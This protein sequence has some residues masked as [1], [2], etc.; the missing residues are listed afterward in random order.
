MRSEGSRRGVATVAIQDDART[1]RI[2]VLRESGILRCGRG[3]GSGRRSRARVGGSGW[4][5][6]GGT[7]YQAACVSVAAW[8]VRRV[9]SLPPVFMLPGAGLPARRRSVAG[10]RPSSAGPG[11]SGGPAAPA[12]RRRCPHAPAPGHGPVQAAGQR[13]IDRSDL[14]GRRCWRWSGPQATAASGS[15]YHRRRHRR[16]PAP[17][18]TGLQCAGARRRSG[19][20]P[21]EPLLGARRRSP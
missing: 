18:P 8:F 20:G 4:T 14:V 6:G 13:G 19:P 15:P 12:R 3:R 17:D 16:T 11:C 2:G 7:G 5:P 9:G 21:M 1:D 10:R